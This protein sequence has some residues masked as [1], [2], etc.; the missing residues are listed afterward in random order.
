MT[1]RSYRFFAL[2]G[3]RNLRRDPV[4]MLVAVTG[5][6]FAVILV[7]IEIGMLL[8]LV[9]NASILIDQSNA[10]IWVSKVDVKTFDFATPFDRRY[11]TRIE[12]VPGVAQIEEYNISYTMWKLPTGGNISVQV[13]GIDTFAELS[14][15][16]ELVAGSLEDLHNRDCVIIDECE[17]KK[18]GNVNLG[19]DVEIN[20]CRAKIA[21]F[22]RG[23]QN[24]TTTPFVFTSLRRS[25]RYGWITEQGR[26]A[27][28]FL[29]K[30]QPG[31]DAKSVCAAINA[32]APGVEA[33]TREGFS[34]RTRKYW[35]L[36]TGVGI[37]FLV[38]SFL[39][40]LVGGVVVSQTLYAMT[41]EKL[42]EY[43]LLKS[44]G[45]NMGEISL[46]VLMQALICGALG[47]GLGLG[48]SVIMGALAASAGTGVLIPP[49]LIG[50]VTLLVLLLCSG[51][52]VISILKL[53][54]L[55][56]ATVFRT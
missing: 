46:V 12:S 25:H 48:V 9:R 4:R 22:T 53:R 31:M 43:G 49:A 39:G 17:R 6:V 7:T 41:V 10:D 1:N 42:G 40:L 35:L 55:E 32:T 30:T 18:L 16:L 54:R 19:D 21:G 23:M 47:L 36:E 14:P 11:K 26:T 20:G 45:A 38:A 52:S 50:A 8:G 44:I 56:P 37:G 33:H 3:W 2:M 27:I 28:Y 13:V 15:R 51:A 34:W 5:V 29:V 24:F